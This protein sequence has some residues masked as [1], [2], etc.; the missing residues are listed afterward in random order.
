MPNFLAVSL[1]LLDSIA[2]STTLTLKSTVY[3]FLFLS[4]GGI[5]VNVI[6]EITFFD[7][8]SK[9]LLLCPDTLSI[10]WVCHLSSQFSDDPWRVIG[11]PT[12]TL[13]LPIIACNDK[14]DVASSHL[15]MELAQKKIEAASLYLSFY[16]TH[17]IWLLS[18]FFPSTSSW[19]R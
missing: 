1:T 3:D 11:W 9:C 4:F 10:L 2:L 13:L 7:F 19:H 15:R 5:A 16:F 14:V 8:F 18:L 6:W 12:P 17:L